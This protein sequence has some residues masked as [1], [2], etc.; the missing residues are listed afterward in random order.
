[1]KV[2]HLNCGTLHPPFRRLVNAT[3][4][5]FE[6]ATMVCHCLLIET[7]AGLVLVDSG[8]GTAEAADPIAALGSRFVRMNRPVADAD[9]T[10]IAQVTKLGYRPEDVRH[11]V[12]THLDLDHA[13]GIA[14]FPW[15]RVHVHA[16]E[17]AAGMAP[18]PAERRRYRANQWQHD[19]HWSTYGPGG[20][21]WFGFGDVRQLDGLPPQIL[22]VPLFGHTRG[23]CAV[24]VDAGATWLFHAG[25]SYFF[26]RETDPQSPY[27][28]PV[29]RLFQNHMQVDR[30]SRLANQERLRR[31]RA[32]HGD[33]VEVFSAHDAVELDRYRVT[34]AG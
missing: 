8:L 29:L 4:K 15:A 21:S 5:L 17:H 1:L 27:C 22:L 11:I 2:H 16:N 24:A 12:L 13:G 34:A 9:Q 26:H 19:P 32:E 30:H 14:D 25:D 6:S 3:G 20:E 28:P 7:D 33:T 18:S 23:H 31:L 10:A